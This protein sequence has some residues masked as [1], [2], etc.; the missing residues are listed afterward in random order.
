MFLHGEDTKLH[1]CFSASLTAHFVISVKLM[2][3]LF[4]AHR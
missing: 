2:H 4:H 3:E 1:I